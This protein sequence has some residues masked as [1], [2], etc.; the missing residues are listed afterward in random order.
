M[1][2]TKVGDRDPARK[3]PSSGLVR[4]GG[5]KLGRSMSSGVE[6]SWSVATSADVAFPGHG[7]LG[8]AVLA[9]ATR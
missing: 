3:A 5:M 7:P 8:T 1:T 4:R 9:T 6:A 2:I